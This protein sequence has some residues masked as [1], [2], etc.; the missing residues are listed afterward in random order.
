MLGHIRAFLDGEDITDQCNRF[1][2]SIFRER[3]CQGWAL[4]VGIEK[5]K[6]IYTRHTGLV[7]WDLKS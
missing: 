2:C 6:L 3:P 5:D 1:Y 4:L 7:S